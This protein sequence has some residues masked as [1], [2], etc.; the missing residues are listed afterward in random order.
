ME[1]L[2]AIG[3]LD[4]PII[5]DMLCLS[6]IDPEFMIFEGRIYGEID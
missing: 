2:R 3:W 6:N 4:Q 1:L 5:L